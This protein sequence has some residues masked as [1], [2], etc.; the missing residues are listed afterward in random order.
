M[1]W[2]ENKCQRDTKGTNGQNDHLLN[3]NMCN[4]LCFFNGIFVFNINVHN[5]TFL[6]DFII[7]DD[8]EC[9]NTIGQRS[10]ILSEVF[11]HVVSAI[12]WMDESDS[13]PCNVILLDIVCSLEVIE[14]EDTLKQ[15]LIYSIEDN[16]C[17]I[18]ST[19]TSAMIGKKLQKILKSI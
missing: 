1:V 9:Q 2:G 5:L 7:K 13:E 19:D 15:V 6:Q 14:I 12:W 10:Y 16:V 4:L 18:K 17:L 3:I 11:N 8:E